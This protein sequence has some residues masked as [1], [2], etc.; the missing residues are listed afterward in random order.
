[1]LSN[2]SGQERPKSRIG[3]V[4]TEIVKGRERRGGG[5]FIHEKCKQPTFYLVLRFKILQ[6]SKTSSYNCPCV[7]ETVLIFRKY[8]L[9]LLYAPTALIKIRKKNQQHGDYKAM[10]SN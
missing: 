6:I 8:L 10:R 3:G 5:Y 7:A 4:T 1:M 9:Y 2:H